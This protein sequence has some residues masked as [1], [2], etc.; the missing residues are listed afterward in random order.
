MNRSNPS[1]EVIEHYKDYS[2]P[3]DVRAMTRRLLCYV[4]PRYLIGL[5]HV[6][7][8][9]TTALPRRRR[10]GKT[11]ARGRKVSIV[12][13]GGVYHAKTNTR[14]A[15]IEVFVD[16]T[17]LQDTVIRRVPVLR[18]LALAEILYHELGHHIHATLR[19]EHREPEGVADK[20]ERRL[21][22]LYFRKRYWYLMPIMYLCSPIA[23]TKAFKRF[24]KRMHKRFGRG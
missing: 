7:L 23:K 2:P 6:V 18:D 3:T 1:V 4:S 21:T 10:R 24:M 14:P 16:N 8:T 13:A 15:W 9:N 11:W 20:W 5:G 12:K 19:P 22:A 17:V